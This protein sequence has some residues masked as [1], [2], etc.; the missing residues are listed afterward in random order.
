[1]SRLKSYRRKNPYSLAF[2]LLLVASLLSLS[3][4]KNFLGIRSLPQVII[5]PFQVVTVTIWRGVTGLPGGL[6][7]LSSLKQENSILKKEVTDLRARLI[8]ADG[9]QSENDHLKGVLAFQQRGAYGH[10]LIPAPIIG[11][12]PTPW[13]SILEIARGSQSGIRK[14]QAVVADKGLVGQVVEVAPLNAKVRLLIDANSAVAA[15]DQRSR[16]QGI[17]TGGFAGGL[18]MHF[19]AAGGNVE[20]GDKILTSSVSTVFPPNILIGQVS[21]VTKGEHDLFFQI[22]IRPAVNFSKL[23]EVFVVK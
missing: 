15:V 22:A 2:T 12:S 18:Q 5:Y 4:F 16:D 7:G 19:V 6:I 17:V 13:F 1:V 23:E 8:F 21:Q 14:N 10:S 3:I 9:L 11:R 20:V